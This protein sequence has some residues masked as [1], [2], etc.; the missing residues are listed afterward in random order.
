M[1]SRDSSLESNFKVSFKFQMEFQVS[2]RVP[3][4]ASSFNTQTYAH[5]SS[6][7]VRVFLEDLAYL[8]CHPLLSSSSWLPGDWF[9]RQQ[10]M[11]SA[12]D[13]AM[14]QADSAKQQISFAPQ[15]ATTSVTSMTA[16]R[17]TRRHL[18]AFCARISATHRKV[19]NS[20]RHTFDPLRELLVLVQARASSRECHVPTVVLFHGTHGR[21]DGLDL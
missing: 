16:F 20:V 7:T 13:S 5:A 6:A 15:S 14:S 21:S 12:V 18:R 11:P 10:K 17:A 2:N 4:R 19:P 8:R 3:N 9:T 1:S